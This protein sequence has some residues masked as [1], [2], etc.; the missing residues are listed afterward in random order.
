[1][2][3]SEDEAIKVRIV[4]KRKADVVERIKQKFREFKEPKIQYKNLAKALTHVEFSVDHL[5]T[6]EK[7]INHLFLNIKNKIKS[8]LNKIL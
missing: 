7:D 2:K 8:E 5:K 1:L 4:G 3:K 6:E